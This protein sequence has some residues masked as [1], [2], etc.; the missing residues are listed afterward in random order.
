MARGMTYTVDIVMV[1][2]ATG[3]MTPII[4]AV[5]SSALSFYEDLAKAMEVKHKTIDSLRVRV[6]VF[7]DFYADSVSDA[8]AT[9]E[10]FT[11]PEQAGDFASYVKGISAHG[12]GDLPESGLEGLA[13]AMMSDWARVGSKRR[14]VIVLWTDAGAHPLEKRAGSKPVGYPE[15]MPRDL[16]DLTDLWESG[17]HLEENA[18]RLILYAPEAAGWTDI[19]PS[20]DNT[21]HFPSNGGTGL[22]DLEYDEI[23]HTIA[24]SIG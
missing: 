13:T 23:L 14:Q 20:W 15:D 22:A 24:N 3:S 6:V 18:K 9:S 10:F 11:L 8:L 16:D 19:A 7:R 21:I 17:T 1:I 4:E 12:G 5:K 2:D